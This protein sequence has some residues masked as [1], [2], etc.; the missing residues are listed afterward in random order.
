MENA[1]VF[2]LSHFCHFF[3]V[4]KR[5]SN[6]KRRMYVNNVRFFGGVA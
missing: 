4:N 1:N 3:E 6:A 2:T 5:E